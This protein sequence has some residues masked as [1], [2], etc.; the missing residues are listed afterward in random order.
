TRIDGGYKAYRAHV[1]IELTTLPTSFR[2]HVLCGPTG[3][4]KSRLLRHLAAQGAQVLDLEQLA[5]HRGSVLGN[6]PDTPQPAQKRFES[7]IWHLMRG[8]NPARPVFV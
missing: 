4:G 7:S 1:N 6:L 2:F 3:S 8:F 5:N